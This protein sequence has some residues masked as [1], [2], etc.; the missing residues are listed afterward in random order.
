MEFF[1]FFFLFIFPVLV[2]CWIFAAIARRQ[3]LER[4]VNQVVRTNPV[5]YT[6]PT[7]VYTQ[8]GAQPVNNNYS[9]VY[10]DQ[11]YYQQSYQPSY[12]QPNQPS[13]PS[14]VQ[15]QPPPY[16]QNQA[17]EYNPVKLQRF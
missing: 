2:F 10:G 17:P 4:N 1:W 15:S 11:I 12:Q 8:P 13:T 7:P 3:R 5:I 6:V 16:S 14:S 9:G